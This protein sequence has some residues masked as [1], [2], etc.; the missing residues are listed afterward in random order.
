MPIYK[1][2]QVNSIA[3]L[4]VWH[5][6]EDEQSLTKNVSLTT[7]CNQRLQ[8][9]SHSNQRKG[10]LAV[11][12]LVEAAGI[13]LDQLQ[14]TTDGKPYLEHGPHISFSHTNDFAAVAVGNAPLG[15]DVERHRAKVKRVAKKFVNPADQAPQ[16]TIAEL[17][18]LW[19]AKESM[20]KAI[21]IPGIRF[22]KDIFVDLSKT[23]KGIAIYRD[24]T[25]DLFLYAWQGHSCVVTIKNKV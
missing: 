23:E 10:F 5:I 24:Q 20:Y 18:D 1:H 4:W 19:C 7:H 8:A 11:R 15:V 17:T 25:Y 12:S 3:N 22:S 14:Y 2:H 6:S 9:M 13:S 21:S 16:Q